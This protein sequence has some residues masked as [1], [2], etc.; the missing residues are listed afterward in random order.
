MQPAEQRTREQLTQ[1][2]QDIIAGRIF[3]TNK[4]AYLKTSFWLPILVMSEEEIQHLYAMEPHALFEYYSRAGSMIVNG[5]PMFFSF[6]VI[7]EEEWTI[8]SPLLAQQRQIAGSG[9]ESL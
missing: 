9:Y 1:I 5:L 8:L 6:K 7:T 3:I 4:P 2:A